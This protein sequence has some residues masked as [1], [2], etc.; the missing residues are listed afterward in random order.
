MI[1]NFHSFNVCLVIKNFATK[2]TTY[3]TINKIINFPSYHQANRDVKWTKKQILIILINLVSKQL[4]SF[5]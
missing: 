4:F 5:S 2:H 1:C 3:T